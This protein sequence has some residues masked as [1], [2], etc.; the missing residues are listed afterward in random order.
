MSDTGGIYGTSIAIFGKLL[1]TAV[2]TVKN[3]SG[4]ALDSLT[5]RSFSARIALSIM[6]DSL[7][8]SGEV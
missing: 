3:R 8:D 1:D 7:L 4:N 2:V 5:P 6:A